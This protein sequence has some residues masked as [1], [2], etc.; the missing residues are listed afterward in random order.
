MSV[1]IT[2]EWRSEGDIDPIKRDF[3]NDHGRKPR[4][5]P[6][7]DSQP[8]SIHRINTTLNR[9]RP[10]R[11]V[12]E[13]LLEDLLQQ[14]EGCALESRNR[15]RLLTARML[16]AALVCT[17]HYVDNCEF[18]AAGDLLV[19]PRQILIHI[20][21]CRHPVIKWRH[22][23]L[24]EQLAA[25]CRTQPFPAWFKQNAVLEISKPALVPHLFQRL[26]RFQCFRPAYLDSIRRRIGKAA[27]TIGFLSA[28]GI[29]GWEDM[30]RR[31]QSASPQQRGFIAANLCRFDLVDFHGLGREIDRMA[32]PAGAQSKYLKK[33]I[34]PE[35]GS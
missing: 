32:H 28:W 8:W 14:N 34:E 22:G 16:E 2:T 31:I 26:E 23:K 1:S 19:N 9:L 24:S 6:K 10:P 13:P 4:S 29:T 30:H 27:D 17:G 5:Q 35:G 25:Y 33:G 12:T 11:D 3:P 18:T 20:R 21:G 15:Y 7:M